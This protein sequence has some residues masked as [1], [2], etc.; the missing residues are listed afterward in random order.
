M[1]QR[2]FVSLQTVLVGLLCSTLAPLYAVEYFGGDA[3]SFYPLGD[4]VVAQGE[5]VPENYN[6]YAPERRFQGQETL[7]SPA[8]NYGAEQLWPGYA[9]PP[10]IRVFL[11]VE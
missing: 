3:Q 7:Q 11:E 1:K 5:F 4:S 6:P 8:L 10:V 9:A 2:W